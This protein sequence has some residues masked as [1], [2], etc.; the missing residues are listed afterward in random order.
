MTTHQEK[1]T[2]TANTASIFS[3]LPELL[4]VMPVSQ[5]RSSLGHMLEHG[6]YRLDVFLSPNRQSTEG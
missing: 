6:F 5:R 4:H 1:I 3:V 2:T